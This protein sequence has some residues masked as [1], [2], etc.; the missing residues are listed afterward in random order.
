MFTCCTETL[1]STN[2]NQQRFIRFINPNLKNDNSSLT[3]Q[4]V[5]SLS[6]W[7]STQTCATYRRAFVLGGSSGTRSDSPGDTNYHQR[8]LLPPMSVQAALQCCFPSRVCQALQAVTSG[9][10]IDRLK[11]PRVH[12]LHEH[13]HIPPHTHRHHIATVQHI[14]PQGKA[15]RANVTPPLIGKI[16]LCF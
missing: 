4:K 5:T 7:M 3:Q 2:L 14:S 16:T 11:C 15:I 12:D 10:Q 8:A 13:Q 1:L 6:L 9:R